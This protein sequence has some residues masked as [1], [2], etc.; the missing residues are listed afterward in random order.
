MAELQRLL[1]SIH[2]GNKNQFGAPGVFK[3]D[4]GAG[5]QGQNGMGAP[6]QNGMP[7]PAN[8]N[9]APMPAN[10]NH[11]SPTDG[12]NSNLSTCGDSESGYSSHG[13]DTPSSTK[14]HSPVVSQAPVSGPAVTQ[15]QTGPLPAHITVKTEN[16]M[17]HVLLDSN[18]HL[19]QHM[20][21]AGY[22]AM[23]GGHQ[24]MMSTGPPNMAHI[25]QPPSAAQAYVGGHGPNHLSHANLKN[26]QSLTCVSSEYD[27]QHSSNTSPLSH[28]ANMQNRQSTLAMGHSQ[29][30]HKPLPSHVDEFN[31]TE[32]FRNVYIKQEPDMLPASTCSSQMSPHADPDMPP[33]GTIETLIPE[34][35][36]EPVGERLVL[37]NQV[38]ETITDAHLNTCNYTSEKVDSGMKKY[39]EMLKHNPSGMPPHVVEMMKKSGMNPEMMM[40]M[41]KP[42]SMD[43]SSDGPPGM[44]GMPPGMPPMPPGGGSPPGLDMMAM[45]SSM[46]GDA[47]GGDGGD[48]GDAEMVA[49][50]MFGMMPPGMM[51]GA[52]GGSPPA[53]A[54]GSPEAGDTHPSSPDNKTVPPYAKPPG[55]TAPMWNK[56]VENMVPAITRVVRF[57][58]RIPGFAELPQEDQIKLIKQGSYEVV[59]ARYT[60][61]FEEDGMFVPTMEMKVPRFMVKRMPMGSFFEEQF[62]FAKIFNGLEYDDTEVG[63]I[64]AIM[65]M[66]PDRKDLT[67]KKAIIKLEGL[68]LQSFYWYM[69]NRRKNDCE[70][71]FLKGL[72]SLPRLRW[73][74]EHHAM[75][76][77]DMKM[78][79]PGFELPELHKE[80]YD[81]Q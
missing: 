55:P 22:V 46:M 54:Q 3:F 41:M 30:S 9:H 19:R 15:A 68:F 69:K 63:L 65:I 57:C 62:S 1:Q 35:R 72:Y 37:V 38:I 52:N 49:K 7:N 20:T 5:T 81:G 51:R 34:S 8:G 14:S 73:I 12:S 26:V 10:G 78:T 28:L 58:K 33:L 56:F 47:A 75:A 11:A 44:P 61:L 80:V 32:S 23:L 43:G 17:S 70:N 64:T 40:S 53:A 24:A 74:N 21:S 67:N 6:G 31:V 18:G 60:R 27:A 50:M 2:G 59:V 48:P 66:N 29:S 45:M 71:V 36:E 76:I 16:N 79:M 25:Q 77:N 4:Q 42:P 39:Y 13:G